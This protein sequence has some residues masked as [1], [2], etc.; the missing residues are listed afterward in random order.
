MARSTPLSTN[1]LGDFA[2]AHGFT[3][4][5]EVS[6]FAAADLLEHLRVNRHVDLGERESYLGEH[7]QLG[8]IALSM[9]SITACWVFAYEALGAR[10]QPY[11]DAA[12]EYFQS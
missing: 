5:E 12:G 11:R 7:P 9:S 4:G 3:H 8:T 2:R 10:L 6:W 1:I